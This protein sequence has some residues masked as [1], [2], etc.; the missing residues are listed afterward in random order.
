MIIAFTFPGQGSQSVGM[1]NGYSDLPIIKQ[2]FD[3]GSEILGYDCFELAKHGPVE[4]LNLTIHTQPIM[5]M[6]GIAVYRAWK[7]L[8]GGSPDYL[9]G[10][11]LGEYTALVAAEA[12]AFRDAIKLV[13]YRAEVMQECVPNGMGA[14]AA[15][16]GL[17]DDAVKAI[18]NQIVGDNE[19]VVLEPA[20]FNSPGQIV[21]AGHKA[22]VLEGMALAKSKGAKLV[23]L[24]PLSIP[25]HCSLMYPAA[26]K[27]Q[28]LLEQIDFYSPK[29]PV[30]HNADVQQ[31][32]Q[33]NEIKKI[34]MQQ[35]HSPVHWV[36]TI[37]SFVSQG[38]T[39]IVE[40]GPGKV[41]SGLTKRIDKTPTNYSLTDSESLQQ[42]IEKLNQPAF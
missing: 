26:E 40:C 32:Q 35:I 1:L 3:E 23:T 30:I 4:Q 17:E 29:I 10:H 21:I 28:K 16:I 11:S 39:H 24:L 9:A 33:S 14:M 22:A 36:N 5:L 6:A 34:L 12:L 13:R 19:K 20:N 2:T 27:F 38:V 25:S 37:Q 31:H 7:S 41:L 8:G 15:I 18:C 42:A